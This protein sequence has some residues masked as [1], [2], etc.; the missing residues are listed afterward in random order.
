[1]ESAAPMV[2]VEAVS[3]QA[4]T[5]DN[6][7]RILNQVSLSVRQGEFLAIMGASGSGKS[8]LLHLIGL[9]D[10]PTSGRIRIQQ[11]P[12]DAFSEPDLARFRGRTIG[13]IFQSFHLLPYLTAHQ[14]VMLP[15]E[16]ARRPRATVR[17][18]ELLV[19]MGLSHRRNAYPATLSGGERQRVAI[20]RALANDPALLLADEPTGSLDSES[21]RQVMDLIND[22]HRTGATV[23]LVT[24]DE[25]VAARAARRV[26][27][28]D[29]KL[30]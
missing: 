27:M 21:G 14:N 26:R 3:H 18:D 28:T 4:G 10:R 9:L 30:A 12:I 19:R 5:L 17:A 13:F 22:L 1:M 2:E 11:R 15:M 6:P 20:A 24:H 7:V 25:S 16:Y 23:I 8:T 29:G